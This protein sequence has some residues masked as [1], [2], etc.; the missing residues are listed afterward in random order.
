MC[1]TDT[2]RRNRQ[3]IVS[4]LFF[5]ISLGSNS[6]AA[7]LKGR[8]TSNEVRPL[9]AATVR[10][11]AEGGQRVLEAKANEQGEYEIQSLS[12]GDYQL[13]VEYKGQLLFQRAFSFHGS[14]MS[15]NVDVCTAP[16]R[17][18]RWAVRTSILSI[19]KL[20]MPKKVAMQEVMALPSPEGIVQRDPRYE[21]QR[22]PASPNSLGVAEGDILMIDGWVKRT[23]QEASGDWLIEISPTSGLKGSLIVKVPP[24]S[25]VNSPDLRQAV[26]GV[27]DTIN[28]EQG[29]LGAI[30][31]PVRITGQLFFNT[32]HL[33]DRSSQGAPPR[34]PWELNP[35][36]EI[37]FEKVR[38]H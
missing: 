1:P 34:V 23:V 7:T 30:A 38:P 37:T 33:S 10:V 3:L 9:N 27:R 31:Q 17:E 20:T 14:E 22:I 12:N 16:P 25:C 5:I 26:Q 13:E 8:V 4:L 28:A 19:E 11:R 15:E 35:V 2:N 21:N 29:R 24:A 18:A 6:A 32:A 36:V